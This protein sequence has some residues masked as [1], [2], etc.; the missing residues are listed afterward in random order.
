MLQAVMANG[1]GPGTLC[2]VVGVAGVPAGP[3]TRKKGE[4]PGIFFFG[5][6]RSHTL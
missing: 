3:E 2:H 6:F 4:A 1:I 5:C